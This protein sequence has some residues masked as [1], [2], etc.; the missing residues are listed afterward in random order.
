MIDFRYPYFQRVQEASALSRDERTRAQGIADEVCRRTETHCA[1][2]AQTHS[3][4]FY[5]RSVDEPAF[6]FPFLVGRD[7]VA[8]VK[9]EDIE[10]M[11]TLIRM[12]QM[13]RDEKDEIAAQNKAKEEYEAA[14]AQQRLHDDVRPDAKNYAAFL[15][16][17]RRGVA[18]VISA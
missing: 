17:K 9:R 5:Y 1:W 16:R 4:H 18:R 13:P 14:K 3:L 2:N 7:G 8:P 15:L 6:A 12:G 10:D 11:V